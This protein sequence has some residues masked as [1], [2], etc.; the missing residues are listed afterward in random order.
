MIPKNRTSFE[1]FYE[2][3]TPKKYEVE[4]FFWS[5][6]PPSVSVRS[7]PSRGT[8][9]SP[10][11]W[12]PRAPLSSVK[13]PPRLCPTRCR[14]SSP[15]PGLPPPPAPRL[16]P[17]RGF[18][19]AAPRFRATAGRVAVMG[20]AGTAAVASKGSVAPTSP[21]ARRKAGGK[22]GFS[23]PTGTAAATPRIDPHRHLETKH[24]RR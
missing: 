1:V 18:P 8:R 3:S 15:P 14:C 22:L 12:H 4:N 10:L 16:P 5:N 11:A 17:S 2:I 19:P 7:L 24:W 21:V 23:P 6:F 13:K 20:G 9:A